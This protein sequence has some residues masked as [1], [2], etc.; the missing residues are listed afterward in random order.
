MLL[1]NLDATIAYL[2][3][4]VPSLALLVAAWYTLGRG[5]IYAVLFGALAMY[6]LIT[7][8]HLSTLIEEFSSNS[9]YTAAHVYFV[10]TVLLLG[11]V[12]FW[13]S[14]ILLPRRE[15]RTKWVRRFEVDGDAHIRWAMFAGI[16]SL[17]LFLASHGNLDL[18]WSE[19]RSEEGFSTVVATFLLLFSFPGITSAILK[20]RKA[21]AIGLIGLN[22]TCFVLSGSRAAAL[23]SLAFFGW[24]MLARS[25]SRWSRLRILIGLGVVA[26]LVHVSL[27]FIRG[28]GLDQLIDILKNG[29]LWEMFRASAAEKD[30]RPPMSRKAS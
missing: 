4:A 25:H 2:S 19:T 15:S 26:L 6:G 28:F 3:L 30:I 5:R 24:I 16:A 11:S 23:G 1:E 14:L 7:L 17:A 10:G 13:D 29:N 9:V 21:I 8:N 22:L 12:V 27:R 18:S 20:G